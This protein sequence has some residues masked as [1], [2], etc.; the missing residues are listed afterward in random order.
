MHLICH[1]VSLHFSLPLSFSCPNNMVAILI[2]HKLVCS[3]RF[4]RK[5]TSWGCCVS[6]LD[7]FGEPA[8]CPEETLRDV[9]C[10]CRTEFVVGHSKSEDEVF[11][12]LTS[13]PMELSSS[14]WHFPVCNG[15]I[16]TVYY[17]FSL[18][19]SS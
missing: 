5:M 12:A 15:K 10:N 18:C 1:Y 7:S 13:A 3:A 6:D 17:R 8:V 14:L 19:C 9:A 2:F 4:Y 16:R 11:G